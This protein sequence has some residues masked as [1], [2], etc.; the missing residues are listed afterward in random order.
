MRRFA[1]H[2]ST[3]A[4][5]LGASLASQAA[6]AT[7]A[8]PTPKSKLIVP[9]TSIGGVKLGHS[10]RK[11]V[12]LWGPG[13]TCG[14]EDAEYRERTGQVLDRKR[15]SGDCQWFVNDVDAAAGAGR[16]RFA[17]GKVLE[18][19]LLAAQNADR[20][21]TGR[22]PIARLKTKPG[23]IHTGSKASAV[24]KA[25]PDAQSTLSG[26]AVFT[27]DRMLTFGLAS[28]KVG[29]IALLYTRNY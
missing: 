9:A 12:R 1:A 21:P 6:P 20:E 29:G 14:A 4:A 10:Y 25:F 8:A 24:R 2:V 27:K 26:V 19:S 18:I 13:S 22:G 7:A 16:I 11:A 23:Q 15:F 5:L 28:G 3:L 17:D